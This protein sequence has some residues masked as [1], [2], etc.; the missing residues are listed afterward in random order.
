MQDYSYLHAGWVTQSRVE[1][2]SVTCK[3]KLNRFLK[4]DPPA[5]DPDAVAVPVAEGDAVLES[6]LGVT[7]GP[8]LFDPSFL[9]IDRVMAARPA[10]SSKVSRASAASASDGENMEYLVK[11]CN[12]GYASC[13]WEHA[14]D[15][16]DDQ[17]I[18]EF[19]KFNTLPL[20]ASLTRARP[21]ASAFQP[22]T[23]SPRYI[24][25]DIY[26]PCT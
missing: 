18:E 19:H 20:A 16:R 25:H 7:A 11:W 13:T 21:P 2:E 26:I 5:W 4:S 15:L 8:E 1:D 3:T 23:E 17:K 10:P 24:C 6:G 14:S 9:E 22:M 12:Q